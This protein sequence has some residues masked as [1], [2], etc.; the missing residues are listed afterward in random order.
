MD[1][2]SAVVFYNMFDFNQIVYIMDKAGQIVTSYEM[3]FDEITDFL[4]EKQIDK[5]ELIGSSQVAYQLK[6]QLEASNMTKYNNNNLK[7]EVTVA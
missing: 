1:I 6:E 3:R 7:I 4:H 5:L 2:F